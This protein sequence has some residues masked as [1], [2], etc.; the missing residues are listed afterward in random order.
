MIAESLKDAKPA[1]VESRIAHQSLKGSAHHLTTQEQETARKKYNLNKWKYA[2]LRDT[3]NT[4]V[5]GSNA[6]HNQYLLLQY[7]YLV[8]ILWYSAPN[9]LASVLN[10]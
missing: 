9:A 4:S 10:T 5:G 3:I 7:Q 1:N 6:R 8:L 2:E